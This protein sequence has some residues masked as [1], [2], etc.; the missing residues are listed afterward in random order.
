MSLPLWGGWCNQ[1][2]IKGF[3]PFE[4]QN[5]RCKWQ[6][7][8]NILIFKTYL[9]RNWKSKAI[10]KRV[11]LRLV[12]SVSRDYFQDTTL[13][14]RIRFSP[15]HN[16]VS[17]GKLLGSKYCGQILY[18]SFESEK[19]SISY[20]IGLTLNSLRV[21]TVLLRWIWWFEI[22]LWEKWIHQYTYASLLRRAWKMFKLSRN[23]NICN[24]GNPAF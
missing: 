10:H 13:T 20:G 8:I 23:V 16:Q 14:K 9:T 4:Y 6:M 11:F 19:R 3:F 2:F 24:R 21:C 18:L 1:L 12:P 5:K 17:Y 22:S 7:A 15:T